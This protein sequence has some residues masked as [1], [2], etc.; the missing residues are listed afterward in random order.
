MFV[1]LQYESGCL[2]ITGL[3]DLPFSKVG[4]HKAI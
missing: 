2:V 3:L 1:T 4:L